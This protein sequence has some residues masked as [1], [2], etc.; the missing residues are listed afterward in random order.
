MTSEISIYVNCRLRRRQNLAWSRSY[1]EEAY[2]GTIY[3][4]KQRSYQQLQA[5]KEGAIPGWV[6]VFFSYRQALKEHFRG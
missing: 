4:M 6:K 2:C 1:S 3:A 5:L